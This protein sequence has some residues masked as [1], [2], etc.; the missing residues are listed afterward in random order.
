MRGS[1]DDCSIEIVELVDVAY[2][3]TNMLL[4]E[5]EVAAV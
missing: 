4:L 1:L 2:A 5:E 3:M